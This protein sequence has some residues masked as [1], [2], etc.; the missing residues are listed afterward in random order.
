MNRL[1]DHLLAGTG[2][3]LDKNSGVHRRN[4]VYLVKHTPEF[5]TRANQIESSHR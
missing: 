3:A 4:H 2:F 1:R 5:G